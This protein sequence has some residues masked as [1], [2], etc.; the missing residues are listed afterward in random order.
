[1]DDLEKEMKASADF[2]T[3]AE[4]KVC[5]NCGSAYSCHLRACRKCHRINHTKTLLIVATWKVL[6]KHLQQDGHTGPGVRVT[7]FGNAI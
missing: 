3:Q 1:M 4:I 6:P 5:L 2:V 7:N